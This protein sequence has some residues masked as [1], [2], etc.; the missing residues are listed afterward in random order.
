MQDAKKIIEAWERCQECK[1]PMHDEAYRQCEYTVGLYCRRDVLI[2][3]TI[4]C[5]KELTTP[6]VLSE[7]EMDEMI[8]CYG[9]TAMFWME[10]R[11]HGGVY[12]VELMGRNIAR[13]DRNFFE[14]R[15]E[16]Y[17]QRKQIGS[18]WRCWDKQ[19]TEEQMETTEWGVKP[20]SQRPVPG[21]TR[22]QIKSIHNELV[23]Y[24]ST[25]AKATITTSTICP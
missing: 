12:P 20:K 8:A 18:S 23:T 4:K 22:E 9:G 16:F 19:P 11:G 6:R 25:R 13:D 17:Y 1:G 5:L 2:L 15:M 24:A 3:D 21:V 14:P 7:E 10:E